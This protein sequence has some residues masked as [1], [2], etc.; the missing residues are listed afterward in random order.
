M[1]DQVNFSPHILVTKSESRHYSH[2][3]GK[4]V[5]GASTDLI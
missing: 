3:A 4:N 2:F 5:L 1:I